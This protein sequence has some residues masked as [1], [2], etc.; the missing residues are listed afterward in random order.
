MSRQ[1]ALLRAVNVGGNAKLAMADLCLAATVAGLK[2]VRPLLQSG[3][4]VFEA[5][6][7]SAAASENLLQAVCAESFG[8]ATDVHVRT[9][10]EIASVQAR[11]PFSAA[12]RDDPSH[13][14]V[15]F[16]KSAPPVSA[17]EAL[18]VAIK[19]RE[20]VHGDG[21][22]AYIVYPDGI[23]RSKLTLGV[24]ERHLGTTATARNWNTVAKLA[25]MLAS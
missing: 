2:D 4:L 1:A 11:N 12:A 20:S 24:I 6:S 23:G 17:F 10:A 9:A 25:A 14:L 8:L 19:G 21:R 7:R 15:L 3:N 16:L 13:L 5:G 18:Q 22:H